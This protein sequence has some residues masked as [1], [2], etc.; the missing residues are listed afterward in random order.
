[1]TSFVLNQTSG[2]DELFQPEGVFRGWNAPSTWG[3]GSASK[4]AT[5]P[6]QKETGCNGPNA[7]VAPCQSNCSYSIRNSTSTQTESGAPGWEA[8]IRPKLAESKLVV[9]LLR[10]TWLKALNISTRNCSEWGSAIW[11]FL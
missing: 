1:M 11:K 6:T 3:I 4:N 7:P 2:E 10:F 9:G 8:K 5:H